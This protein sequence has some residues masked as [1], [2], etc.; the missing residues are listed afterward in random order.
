M[1]N[2]K[3][4]NLNDGENKGRQELETVG[5]GKGYYITNGKAVEISWT[6]DDRT[7]KTIYKYADGTELKLNMGNTYVQI[8]PTNASITIE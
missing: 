4:Y 2:L 1:Y 6:K 3:N 5:S 7:K 8:M